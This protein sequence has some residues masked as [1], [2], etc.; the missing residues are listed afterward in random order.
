MN[1]LRLNVLC[2]V[3]SCADGV[4][5]RLWENII[6]YLIPVE[7]VKVVKQPAMVDGESLDLRPPLF[8]KSGYLTVA[9][10]SSPSPI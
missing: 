9:V 3:K 8:S 5:M 10:I 2:D 7:K 1:Y 4:M 6:E